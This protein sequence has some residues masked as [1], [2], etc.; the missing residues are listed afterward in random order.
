MSRHDTSLAPIT[1]L[2]EPFWERQTDHTGKLE[3]TLWYDRFQ[4]YYLFVGTER[5]KHGAYNMWRKEQGKPPSKSLTRAWKVIM[6]RWRWDERA[7]AW[8]N[9]QRQLDLARW[10]ERRDAIREKEFELA[11][12][13][14]E[15]ALAMSRWPIG[16]PQRIVNE[17]GTVTVINPTD[18]WTKADAARFAK[19]ASDLSRRAAGITDDTPT[20]AVVVPIIIVPSSSAGH[21]ERQPGDIVL[22]DILSDTPIPRLHDP[23]RS[24]GARPDDDDFEDDDDD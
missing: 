5:S 6:A 19:I 24:N 22:G 10:Q 7:E 14:F 15:Q 9:Y 12:R 4:N 8:D 23:G 1:D 11:D 3:P 13:L 21:F 20:G 16:Q 2:Q 17:D 18:K